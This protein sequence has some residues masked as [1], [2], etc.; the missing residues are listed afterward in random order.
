MSKNLAA[1]ATVSIA[2][3]KSQVWDAFVTPAA[4]KQYMFGAD[5]H[6]DWKVGSTA[7]RLPQM[8]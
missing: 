1:T 8:H 6:S 5:V 4:I 2:A 3:D 7:Y